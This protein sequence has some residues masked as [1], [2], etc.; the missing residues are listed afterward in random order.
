MFSPIISITSLYLLY[1]VVFT[2]VGAGCCLEWDEPEPCKLKIIYNSTLAVQVK[3]D[4]FAHHQEHM[5]V[6]TVTGSVHPSC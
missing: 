3:S 5:T 2:Q 4:V 6:F 1:L